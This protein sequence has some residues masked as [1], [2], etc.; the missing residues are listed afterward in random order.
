ML[1][2]PA[3]KDLIL[4]AAETIVARDGSGRLTIDAVAAES[5]ISK[6]GVLYH[7]P[8]KLAML[9]AMVQRLVDSF[10]AEIVQAE[11]AAR[12]ADE[13][14][15]PHVVTVLFRRVSE[16]DTVS[17]ALL[18]ASAEQPEL[19]DTASQTITRE[20]RRLAD[21][22]PDPVLAQIVILALDGLKFSQLLGLSHVHD[23]QFDQ[24]QDRLVAM[25][26]EMYA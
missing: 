15:L 7:Y 3:T 18:A 23:D 5:G 10:R 13:P 11:T 6:G 16:P 17:N 8:N 26:R 1:E 2:K 9:Q 12:A 4:D 19:L 25:T 22:A 24:I 20:F 21:E 14:V